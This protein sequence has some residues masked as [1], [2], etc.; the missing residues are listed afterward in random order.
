MAPSYPRGG[1]AGRSW[2]GPAE[3]CANFG[4][5]LRHV[6]QAVK[7]ATGCERVYTRDANSGRARGP[8]GPLALAVP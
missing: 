2:P 4:F 1:L 5:A 3:E 6:Q 8:P 7:R